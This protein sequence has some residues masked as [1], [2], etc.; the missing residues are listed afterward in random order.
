MKKL[1]KTEPQIRKLKTPWPE[2]K[3]E[4]LEFLDTI[5]K[6]PNGYGECVELIAL[7]LDATKN[8]LLCKAGATGF[9]SDAVNI[10]FL[11]RTRNMKH[12]QILDISN[13]LYPQY[14]N[15]KYFPTLS[16]LIF[17]HRNFLK[18]EAK[19]KLKENLKAHPDVIRHWQALAN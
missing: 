11:R 6:H 12:F 14:C 3:E 16:T 1:P 5:E 13:L 15:Q 17:T 19:K 7:F 10:S 2:T 18:T 4:L 8:Y 9:Q